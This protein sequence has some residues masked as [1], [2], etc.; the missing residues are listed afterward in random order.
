MDMLELECVPL[1]KGKIFHV[2]SQHSA[3]QIL[4]TGF[5]KSNKDGSLGYNFSENSFGRKKGYVCLFDFRT[6][7][8]DII[9]KSLEC[10]NFLS[11]RKYEGKMAYL[12][13]RIIFF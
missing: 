10:F 6:A 4:K 5:I 2:T 8:D 11:F 1:L 7:S 3:K 12:F 13:T 9:K